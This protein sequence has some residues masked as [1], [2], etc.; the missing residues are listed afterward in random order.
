MSLV[1]L[2]ETKKFVVISKKQCP[3]CKKL[4][5]MLDAKKLAYEYILLEDYMELF[6][7]DDFI[8]DDIELLKKKWNITA[9]PMTF[10]DNEFIGTYSEIQKMN[11]FDT[12]NN[13]LKSKGIPFEDNEDF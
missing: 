5:E 3:N 4:K 6:D 11:S 9:Y 7:D 1:K 8:F 2:I 13:I 12:F 10:I